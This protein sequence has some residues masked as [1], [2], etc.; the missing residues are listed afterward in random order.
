M[1]PFGRTL[2]ALRADRGRTAIFVGGIGVVLLALWIAWMAIGRQGGGTDSTARVSMPSEAGEHAGAMPAAGAGS[3][4]MPDRTLANDAYLQELMRRY[5]FETQLDK[6]GA[7]LAMLQANPN[8]AVKQFALELAA[9]GDSAKRQEGLE[10]LKAFPDLSKPEKRLVSIPGYP[11][12]LDALPAG[13]RFAPR[14][15]L[16]F[17][18]CMTELPKLYELEDGHLAS[19][20]LVENG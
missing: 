20:F 15:P 6:R 5:A 7:L 16:A 18:R 13:C 17:E 2:G 19:C 1:T 4:A 8:E 3:H 9:S 11:P 10:L 14:C 12:K